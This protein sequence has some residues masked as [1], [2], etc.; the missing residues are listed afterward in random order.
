MLSITHE[1][2]YR[3]ER[4]EALDALA[5]VN[6]AQALFGD[7]LLEAHEYEDGGVLAFCGATSPFTHALALAL[8]SPI[9]EADIERVE[10]FFQ[11]RDAPVLI[12]VTPY[13][14]PSLWTILSGRGY[15]IVEFN[16]V[17]TSVPIREA[18]ALPLASA[19][20]LRPAKVTESSLYAQTAAAGFFSRPEISEQELRVGE[21]IFRMADTTILL[22][23][24]EGEAVGSAC[25]SMRNGVANFFGDSTLAA[26]RNKGI[27][28][29]TIQMRMR[30][31]FDAG[32]E[33]LAAGCQAGSQSQLNY[34][35]N[36]FQ[37]AYSKVVMMLV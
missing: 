17:L 4:A 13:S 26:Y 34:E 31:A 19:A 12:D 35:R 14:D 3:L 27:Q 15:Q 11:S 33:L 28:S 10:D 1:L 8:D 24:M 29:S 21:V 22:A 2:A 9:T 36:G 20:L 25:V 16:N 37:V 32:C 23:E 7:E 30:M 5:C 6:S 18:M